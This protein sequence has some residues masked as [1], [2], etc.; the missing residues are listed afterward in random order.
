MTLTHKHHIIPKHMGGT[1]DPSNIIELS[2]ENHAKAHLELYEKYGNEYD[3][4]AYESL[5]KRLPREEIVRQVCRATH[6]GKPKNPEAVEKMR[7][8]KTGVP[9][10]PESSEKKRKTMLKKI[11]EG[12]K[13]GVSHAPKTEEHNKKNS[14]GCKKAWDEGNRK[15]YTPGPTTEDGRKKCSERAKERWRQYRIER[16]LD[17]DT[18]IKKKSK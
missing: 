5:M 16:G 17:P 1:D 8:T 15:E 4:I 12:W 18:P 6:L 13:P 10:S 14:E 3:R 2:V 7:K 11:E 9:M